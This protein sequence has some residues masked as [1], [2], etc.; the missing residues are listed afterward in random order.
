MESRWGSSTFNRYLCWKVRLAAFSQRG[1]VK[2]FASGHTLRVLDEQRRPLILSKAGY[3]WGG[4]ISHSIMSPR[5]FRLKLSITYMGR[6]KPSG[7][8]NPR[9]PR[10]WSP[11]HYA[12]NICSSI[13]SLYCP[14]ISQAHWTETSP[15]DPL[16]WTSIFSHLTPTWPVSG[17]EQLVQW[18]SQQIFIEVY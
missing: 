6:T 7:P 1:K 18:L 2:T 10:F 17:L 9:I 14:F 4:G 15:W 5:W 8:E 3:R 11:S 13:C 16:T 12:K